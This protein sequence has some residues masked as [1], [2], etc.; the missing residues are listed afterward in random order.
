MEGDAVNLSV[1]IGGYVWRGS[2]EARRLGL[3]FCARG[4]WVLR[5]QV[6]IGDLSC[7]ARGPLSVIDDSA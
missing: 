4:K 5:C 7:G 2:E 3:G 6:Q 1:G